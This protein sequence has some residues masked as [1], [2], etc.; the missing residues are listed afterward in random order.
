VNVL[1]HLAARLVALRGL[2]GPAVPDFT[3]RVR[4]LVIIASSS[5]GGSSMLA[6]MLR[7]SPK[8]LHLRAEINPFFRIAGLN[9]PDSGTG[10]D[11][12]DAAHVHGLDAHV[13]QLLDQELALDA[14]T[15]CDIV[16]DEQYALDVAW[17]FS[18]QWPE[19]N[20]DLP[21]F[22]NTVRRLLDR[23][24]RE[25]GW[26]AGEVRDVPRFQLNL[27]RE[28]SEKGIHANPWYYDLA[29][30]QLLHNQMPGGRVLVTP[31]DVLLEE[32]PFVLT[33]PWRRANA[34]D[35][36]TK[37][38]LIKTPSNA[39]RFGCLRALFPNARLRILH[40]TR[41]PAASINGL[42]DGWRHN[43]FYAHRLRMPLQIKDYTENC[44]Q[45]KWWWKFDLPPGWQEYTEAT[46]MEVCG[47]QWRM[48][49]QA[50]LD[51]VDLGETECTRLR[52]E[53]LTRSRASRVACLANLSNWLGI[54]L[55]GEFRRAAQ[56]GI[57]P[58]AATAPPTP[59]RWR[60]RGDVVKA[61]IQGN[62]R[63]TA[64]RLGYGTEDSWI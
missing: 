10:S 21:M 32:P 15:L 11:R 60:A 27:L 45:D 24:R 28:L 42:F 48:C 19:L 50:I 56:D 9:F 57:D 25:H 40:L 44:P 41:N 31:G 20:F 38:L 37:P 46:L 55:D 14:G 61:V 13:R 58:V 17:R 36:E 6:E 30:T 34:H 12:L 4:D 26:A 53:D 51:E 16:D 49:H 43:G 29:P 47:F 52:F 2:R 62:V 22:V 63:E 3:S 54:P 35:V 8:A 23:L 1:G 59:L 5:R 18:V 39:Y 64:E 33:R 7:R